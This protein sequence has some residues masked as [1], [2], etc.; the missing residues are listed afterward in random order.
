MFVL[1]HVYTHAL[2]SWEIALGYPIVSPG[3]TIAMGNYV[4]NP[5]ES[6]VSMTY[7]LHVEYSA[8]VL[9]RCLCR[10][11][12]LTVE[13]A[14][15]HEQQH[16]Q[17]LVDEKQHII[18][19][20]ERRLVALDVANARLLSAIN[21]IKEHR[22]PHSGPHP[23]APPAVLSLAESGQFRTSSCWG[24]PQPYCPWPRVGSLGPAPAEGPPHCA[25][26]GREWAV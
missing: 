7:Q 14:R 20:Q 11:R 17:H 6:M 8:P 23:T 18:D 19:N 4:P 1:L 15:R 16:L 21:Q 26:P 2:R 12:L 5:Q 24:P 22:A 10:C 25:V 13:E 3:S 9:T